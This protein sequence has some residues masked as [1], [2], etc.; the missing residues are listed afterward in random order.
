MARRGAHAHHP[1]TRAT[2]RSVAAA[3]AALLGAVGLAACGGGDDAG[4]GDPADVTSITVQ[5]TFVTDPGATFYGEQLDACGEEVGVDIERQSIPGGDIISRVL[6][7]A[8]SQTLPDVLSIDNPDVQQL[9]DAGALAP[10]DQYGVSAEGYSQGVVDANTYEGELYGL[11]PTTNTLALFY[12]PAA[13]EEAGVEPPTTWDELRS[14]AETLTEGDRYGIAFSAPPSYEGTWQFP[15]LAQNPDV[16]YEVTT[17]P[18][19]EAGGTVS[20]PLGGATWTLPATGDEARQQ[21]AAD[22]IA[23]MGTDENIVEDAL[24]NSTVPSKPELGEQVVAEDPRIQAFVDQVPDLRSRTGELGA[25]WTDAATSIYEAVQTA[26]TGG[27]TPEQ[28][29]EQAQGR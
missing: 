6:Q 23:C 13:L 5:D 8:S 26:L 29:L 2:G 25:E 17:L 19:P 11:Q 27:A 22:V 1:T 7:Q 9:A 4:S 15:V 14:A 18:A 28:A 24:T 10:L 3:A 16:E 21:V 20:A 12:D